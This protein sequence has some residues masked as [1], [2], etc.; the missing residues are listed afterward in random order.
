MR[1]G[2][3]RKHSRKIEDFADFWRGKGSHAKISGER[4]VAAIKEKKGGAG[5]GG[6]VGVYQIYK[7]KREWEEGS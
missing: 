6:T 3:E 1:G 5:R 4:G 2:E 7:R